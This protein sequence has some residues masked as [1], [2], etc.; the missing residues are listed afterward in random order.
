VLAGKEVEKVLN[1]L[2]TE[3]SVKQAVKIA[4]QITGASKK[5]V[6]STALAL[7]AQR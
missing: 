1:I 6:Y 4:Y 3:L 7:T 5:L 2:L